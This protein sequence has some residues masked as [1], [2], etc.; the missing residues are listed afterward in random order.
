MEVRGLIKA[1]RMEYNVPMIR[2]Q[3]KKIFDDN[4]KRWTAKTRPLDKV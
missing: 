2:Y 3:S 4:G 1:V